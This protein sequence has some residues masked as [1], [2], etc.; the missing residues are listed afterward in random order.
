MTGFEAKIIES[1]KELAAK[2]RIA[3]KDTTT[4]KKLDLETSAGDVVI[5]VDGYVV[6]GI[7]NEKAEDKDY[8]NYVILAKNGERYVT[9]SKSFWSTFKGMYE[10]M[11]LANELDNFSI[12]CTRVESK[13]YK[14]KQFITC[15]II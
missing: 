1:S 15:Q 8:E 6:L 7:H 12:R 13:N 5:D 3:L 10:E 14:G 11:A 4:A 2:E 9:G